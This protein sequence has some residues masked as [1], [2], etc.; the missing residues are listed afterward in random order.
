MRKRRTWTDAEKELIAKIYPN[1][2]NK[3]VAD[4]LHR[5]LASVAMYAQQNGIKK[6]PEYME[7][8]QFGF[9]K[10]HTPHN[11]GVPMKFWMSDEGKKNFMKHR[12]KGG[13]KRPVGFERVD[14][15][16]YVYVKYAEGKQMMLKHRMVWEQANGP[17][18]PGHVII[19][20]DGNKANCSLD[21][22]RLVNRGELVRKNN[23]KLTE[24]QH[25]RRCEKIQEA[26]NRHIKAERARIC[27]GLEPKG[28]LVKHYKPK[29]RKAK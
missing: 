7:K 1:N 24:E 14:C 15:D 4:M 2:S 13:I 18:P 25:K 20:K 11:K 6:S 3:Y 27:F 16:G 26:R 19:F 5:S 22:L 10:G 17:V 9:N 29:K 28:K 21:N 8:M 23:E 12:Y